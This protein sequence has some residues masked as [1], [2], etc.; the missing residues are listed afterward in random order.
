MSIFGGYPYPTTG[1]RHH[2]GGQQPN[3]N[4]PWTDVVCADA[5]LAA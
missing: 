4:R 3:L 5:G 1:R 2:D